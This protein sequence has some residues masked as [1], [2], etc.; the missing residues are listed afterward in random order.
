V[1]ER[2]LFYPIR[3]HIYAYGV[4]SD[5]INIEIKSISV[6]NVVKTLFNETFE[7]AFCYGNTEGGIENE[8]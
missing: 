6:I 1:D 4:T 8:K 5:Y 3:L 7:S 2:L